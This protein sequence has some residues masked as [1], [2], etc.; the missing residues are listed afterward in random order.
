MQQLQQGG[1]KEPMNDY[2]VVNSISVN[3]THIAR[4]CLERILD[5]DCYKLEN[6][7]RCVGILESILDHLQGNSLE[8]HVLNRSGYEWKV[9]ISLKYED[10]ILWVLGKY[11]PSSCELS[12]NT[13]VDK[14][15]FGYA[16]KTKVYTNNATIQL[17]DGSSRENVRYRMRIILKS[18][19]LALRIKLDQ[20]FGPS[21]CNLSFRPSSSALKGVFTARTGSPSSYSN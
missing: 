12:V 9:A 13:I 18:I 19:Y 7:R 16:T 21:S 14:L 11:Y 6:T 15:K 5:G 4:R 3:V 20:S 10:R 2:L 8:L 1:E 17:Y